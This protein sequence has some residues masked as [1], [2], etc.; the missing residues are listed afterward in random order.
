M[1]F[2]GW[3]CHCSDLMLGW[4][5]KAFCASRLSGAPP[6]ACCQEPSLALPG[7]RGQSSLGHHADTGLALHVGLRAAE[8][9][10]CFL[11][12]PLCLIAS[13]PQETHS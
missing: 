7:R 6:S 12:A 13:G 10:S 2:S 3:Q 1:G 11:P 5:G 9:L 8:I 4:S